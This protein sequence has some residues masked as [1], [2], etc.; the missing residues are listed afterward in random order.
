MQ[1]YTFINNQQI[2]PC[3][4]DIQIRYIHEKNKKIF[5]NSENFKNDCY[6]D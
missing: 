1:N 6:M 5:T 3:Y 4:I 2:F